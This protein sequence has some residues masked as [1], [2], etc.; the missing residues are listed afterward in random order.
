MLAF[1]ALNKAAQAFIFTQRIKPVHAA[2]QYFMNIRLMTYIKN[3]FIPR[4]VIAVM[5]RDRQLHHAQI[6]RKMPA[7]H[8][9]LLN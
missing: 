7:C 9:Q 5:Q 3:K 2:G 8:R 6:G 4:T 1:T